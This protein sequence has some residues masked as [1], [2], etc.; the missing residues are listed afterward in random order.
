MV[1]YE[2]SLQVFEHRLSMAVVAFRAAAHSDASFLNF[3]CL[4]YR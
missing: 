3:T 4:L 2:W 1:V